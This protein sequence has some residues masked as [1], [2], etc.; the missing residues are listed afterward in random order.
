MTKKVH[1]NGRILLPGCFVVNDK[2]EVLLL[3]KTKWDHYET[4]GGK[5]DAK[6]C[7]DPENPTVADLKKGAER[8][9][10]E[11]V[12]GIVVQELEFFTNIE[13]TKPNGKPGMANKF[14]A[15]YVSGEP[16][17][18]EPETFSKVKWLPIER[19]DEFPLSPDL[20]AFPE[21]KKKLLNYL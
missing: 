4:P 20:K 10:F 1:N 14:I 18:N 2:R 6:D 5:L 7:V 17:V 9:L 19:L 8:E 16:K 21:L 13:F 15:R 11:E 12:G 3:Y